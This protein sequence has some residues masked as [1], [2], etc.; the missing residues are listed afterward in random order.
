MSQL[1]TQISPH[2]HDKTSTQRIMLD[3]VIALLPASI[4][5]IGLFGL[6]ALLIE[7]LC[8]AACV[9]FEW[10]F[11]KLCGRPSTIGDLSAVVTGLLLALNLP[12]DIAAWQAVFGCAVA[13]IVAKQLFGGIG[14][15][16]ANP[17]ITARIVMLISF[18]S[19]MSK[20][21]IPNGLDA[22]TSATPL[23]ILIGGAEGELPS[24][25]HMFIGLRGGCIGETC[26]LALIIGGVYL[27]ARK[28]ISWH[29]PVAFILT[30]AV[31]TLILKQNVLYH[32]M[33]GGIM[34]GAIFMATDYATTPCT[35]WGKIIFGAGCGFL[36]VVIRMWSV[37]PEGVSFSILLMNILTPFIERA[38]ITKPFGGEKA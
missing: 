28:V 24:L 23:A 33:S 6:R 36:T 38:T 2:I 30:V 25:W 31:F 27:I 12:V 29:T 4:A 3:V 37:Y 19:T 21:A 26:M 18:S 14:K 17:A 20:W 8:V 22:T 32:L 10:A 34:L 11:E 13:I 35:K 1:I 16:F 5:G 7:L 9:F 15:N